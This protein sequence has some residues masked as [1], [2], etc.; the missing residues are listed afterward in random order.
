MDLD[1]AA[2]ARLE[3]AE[4]HFEPVVQIDRLARRLAQAR[5][6]AQV[7]HDGRR[8]LRATRHHGDD[9]ARVGEELGDLG[10]RVGRRRLQPAAERRHAAGNECN[11]IIDLVR[12]AR[13]QAAERGHLLRL[14]EL[15]LGV[16]ELGVGLR[17]LPVGALELRSPLTHPLLEACV[18]RHQRLVRARVLECDRGLVREGAQELD[19]ARRVGEPRALAPGAQHPHQ[20]PAQLE[21]H[22]ERGAEG[23]EVA[24][25]GGVDGG[26][27]LPPRQPREEGARD[28]GHV[29]RRTW[30]AQVELRPGV[31]NRLVDG[32]AHQGHDPLPLERRRQLGADR[33]QD[34]RAVVA[35]AEE[36][37]VDE[38]LEPR[39]ERV[40]ED[41]DGEREED[42][43]GA[44]VGH[45]PGLEDGEEHG[46]GEVRPADHA[47]QEEV[48]GAAP[49]RDAAGAGG[50]RARGEACSGGSGL[51]H[52]RHWSG[53]TLAQ[54]PRPTPILL[55]QG[56]GS[57][58]GCRRR[59]LGTD[60][61]RA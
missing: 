29:A 50:R 51:R 17:Q 30:R 43:E 27:D 33:G 21:R 4:A 7:L 45:L 1:P 16:L 10:G 60:P 11:R 39:A 19:V 9:L 53:R 58:A 28:A 23:G 38:G 20:L 57:R 3:Q 41:E 55:A 6:A 35:G 42:R 14:H 44:R 5:E 49:H 15:D 46:G 61:A 2:P 12:H 52:G 48:V 25:G 54:R 40:E 26:Q 22:G 32:V 56:A 31:G 37:P 47:G 59:P 8:A 36:D 34:L 18:E 24:L 13:H